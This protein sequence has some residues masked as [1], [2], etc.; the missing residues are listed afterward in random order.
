MAYL[1]WE[2]RPQ[3]HRPILVAAFEG[4]ND[5]GEAA[6]TAVRYIAR[7]LEAKPIATIDP[8]DFYDFT[9]ARPHVRLEDGLTRRIDWPT[10]TFEAATGATGAAATGGHDIVLLHS[11]EP[12]LKW[13]TF[14]AEVVE[15]AQALD[16]EL[17]VTMGALLAEVPHT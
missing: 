16:V 12:A 11:I 7:H 15:A 5:A 17:V 3:L 14:S 10:P 8:E 13:R 4:W 2:R 1:R 6:T 9:V